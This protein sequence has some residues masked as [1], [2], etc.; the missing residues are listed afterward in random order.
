MKYIGKLIEILFFSIVIVISISGCFPNKELTPEQRKFVLVSSYDQTKNFDEIKDYRFSY[1]MDTFCNYKY[2]GTVIKPI[3]DSDSSITG[4]DTISD[5]I[6][7]DTVNIAE[8]ILNNY[9]FNKDRNDTTSN[10]VLHVTDTILKAN[11]YPFKIDSLLFLNKRIITYE[12]HPTFDDT[13]DHDTIYYDTIFY[14]TIV[15]SI[16]E[17]YIGKPVKFPNNISLEYSDEVISLNFFSFNDYEPLYISEN[18]CTIHST[19][20]YYLKD[21]NNLYIGTRK[22]DTSSNVKLIRS[23]KFENYWNATLIFDNTEYCKDLEKYIDTAFI[24]S[25]F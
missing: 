25:P 23:V 21:T 24:W 19:F 5:T 15:D 17:C 12:Y 16:K 13:I 1:N 22:I 20:D 10:Y 3:Y 9:Y 2:L 7:V 4:Y 6:I 14:D 8:L 18:D 11:D